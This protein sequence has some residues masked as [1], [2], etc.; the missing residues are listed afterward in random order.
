MSTVPD[1][2]NP[3][4]EHDTIDFKSQQSA[5]STLTKDIGRLTTGL[6]DTSL[7]DRST[8]NTGSDPVLVRTVKSSQSDLPAEMI[9]TAEASDFPVTGSVSASQDRIEQ[10]DDM[11][12]DENPADKEGT[13]TASW[14]ATESSGEGWSLRGPIRRLVNDD[15]GI[16]SEQNGE[17]TT[18]PL[19]NVEVDINSVQAPGFSLEGYRDVLTLEMMNNLNEAMRSKLITYRDKRHRK[20]VSQGRVEKSCRKG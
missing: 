5:G 10:P 3:S 13:P 19:R 15:H 20:G 4:P 16:N 1:P 17:E 14:V 6:T 9:P 2:H 11:N 8:A 7:H 18:T 12:I